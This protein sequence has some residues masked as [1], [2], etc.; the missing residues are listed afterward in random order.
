MECGNLPRNL[1][2]VLTDALYKD[3]NG[4]VFLN[5]STIGVDCENITPVVQ[6][7]MNI[8]DTLVGESI[9][10]KDSCGN[11]AINIGTSYGGN[12]TNVRTINESDTQLASD[13]IIVC[14]GAGITLTLLEATGSNKILHIKNINVSDVTVDG[15]G[16][17]TIDDEFNQTVSEWE[18]IMILD[19]AV[20]EWLIL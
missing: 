14:D 20:G 19:Y 2:Q 1:I 4:N 18:N 16:G 13:E 11:N 15:D 9:L 10:N 7:G 17:D 8:T 3:A 12:T 6:C 5:I